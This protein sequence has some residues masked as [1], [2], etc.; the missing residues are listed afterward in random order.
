MDEIIYFKKLPCDKKEVFYQNGV[1]LGTVYREIDGYYV[2][3][4]KYNGGYWKAF[5]MK[6]IADKIDGLNKG[7]DEEVKLGLEKLA[8]LDDSWSTI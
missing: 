4:P 3:L 1:L 2:F 5:I 7:W 6:A 8:K